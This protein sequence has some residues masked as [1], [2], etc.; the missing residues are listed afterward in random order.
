MASTTA[1]RDIGKLPQPFTG[2]KNQARRFRLTFELYVRQNAKR[3]ADDGAKVTLFLTLMQGD[4][5]GAWAEL[6][7]ETI[8]ADEE[9]ILQDPSHTPT[10]GTLKAVYDSFDKRFQ[11]VDAKGEAQSSFETIKQDGSVEEYITEFE[12]L[13]PK[14]KYDAEAQLYFFKKGLKPAILDDV[15]RIH[16]VATDLVTY[17]SYALAVDKQARDRK[18]EKERWGGQSS[19]ARH[20]AR[21]NT[22]FRT[23]QSAATRTP[24]TAAQPAPQTTPSQH[25]PMDVDAI[26]RTTLTLDEKRRLIESGGCFYCRKPAAGHV[27]RDCPMKSVRPR[28]RALEGGANTPTASSSS[29]PTPTPSDDPLRAFTE[30]IN[31]VKTMDAGQREEAS[32][33]LKDLVS[34]LD[35]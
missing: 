1:D 7:M 6:V 21:F 15:Y 19:S 24:Q 10:Y 13:A 8:L 25:V 23:T 4:V 12:I 34:T 11:F 2:D 5:A 32:A 27:A 14:T 29:N 16:P 30:V 31:Q 22:F 28:V 18:K 17:K 33:L 9:A 20:G 35:F 26:R 3:Y